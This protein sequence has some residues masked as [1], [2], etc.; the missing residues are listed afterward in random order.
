VETRRAKQLTGAGAKLIIYRAFIED[1]LDAPKH[2]AR[3][4]HEWYVAA[5][6]RIPTAYDVESVECLYLGV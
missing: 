2:L 3:R 4:V 5:T 1:E 6:W